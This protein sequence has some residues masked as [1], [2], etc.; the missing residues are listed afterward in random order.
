MRAGLPRGPQLE[1]YNVSESF[2]RGSK[3]LTNFL[4]LRIRVKRLRG[5]VIA[6]DATRGDYGA[7][8]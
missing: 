4:H 3:G 8:T 2:Q 6:R 1:A 7:R 5:E